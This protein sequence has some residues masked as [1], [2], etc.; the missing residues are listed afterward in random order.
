LQEH[1]SAF[2]KVHTLLRPA[3]LQRQICVN[4]ERTQ[5]WAQ[6][7]ERAHRARLVQDGKRLETLSRVLESISYK[8]V[9][10]RGFALVKGTDGAIRRRAEAVKSGERL[11]LTF[12]DGTREA[13]A[14]GAASAPA[15][16]K[17]RAT[18]P[19]GGQGSLL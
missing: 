14:G 16:A 8:G 10:D 18:K 11:T 19:S 6:R 4:R 1:R 17:P 12:A 13:T 2:A 15:P 5:A 7:M 3:A 9:L